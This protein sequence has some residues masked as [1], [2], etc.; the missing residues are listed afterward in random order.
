MILDRN[1]SL[2]VTNFIDELTCSCVRSTIFHSG[3]TIFGWKELVEIGK[4]GNFESSRLKAVE[5]TKGI[6]FPGR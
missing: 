1:E 5:V 2:L 6:N 4:R 3:A